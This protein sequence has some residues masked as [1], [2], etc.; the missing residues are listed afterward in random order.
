MHLL[1]NADDFG[2]SESVNLA[3]DYCL[4]NNI[5]QRT[6]LMVNMDSSDDAVALAKEH[7]YADKVGLHLNLIEGTPLTEPIKKTIFCTD[8]VF[9]GKALR[10]PKNRFLLDRRTQKAVEGELRAQIEKYVGYG[11]TLLHIDS[12]E[13]T[14][15]NPS[16]FKLLFPLM[17]EY[18][19]L[20]C[21]LSRNIPENEITGVKRIYKNIF[22]K[23][24]STYNQYNQGSQWHVKYFGSQQDV[25]K[26]ALDV[27][28]KNSNIEVEVHPSIGKDG[29]LEDLIHHVGVDAWIRK[30]K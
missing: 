15:T 8:G 2:I 23:R 18:D 13:H 12:H 17:K 3:I 5:V 4:K 28:F 11:F 16:I 27:K 1:I 25:D 10:N 30:Y 7:G 9:N 14:H 20:S 22:N 26:I 19:F 24:V 6:T 21:R 29:R